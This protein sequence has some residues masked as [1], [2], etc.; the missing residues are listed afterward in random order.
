M[1]PVFAARDK[2][3]FAPRKRATGGRERGFYAFDARRFYR[4][5][6]RGRSTDRPTIASRRRC[7]PF[8]LIIS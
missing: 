8:F 7:L 4:G 3:V 1:M 5:A 2:S 6:D